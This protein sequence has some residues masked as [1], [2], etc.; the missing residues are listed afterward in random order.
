MEMPPNEDPPLTW[1]EKDRLLIE[2]V[3]GVAEGDSEVRYTAES[4]RLR[5]KLVVQVGEM[6]AKGITPDMLKD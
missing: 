6:R 2:V 5:R 1:E 3:M 4:E